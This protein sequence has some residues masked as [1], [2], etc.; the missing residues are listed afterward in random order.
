MSESAISVKTSAGSV[1]D[2]ESRKFIMW[3]YDAQVGVITPQLIITTS[4][5]SYWAINERVLGKKR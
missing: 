4:K 5:T 3:W 2:Q 1:G